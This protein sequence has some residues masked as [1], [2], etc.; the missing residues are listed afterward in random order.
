MIIGDV[1]V[2]FD[3]PSTRL[4]VKATIITML[5]EMISINQLEIIIIY[6]KF[7]DNKKNKKIY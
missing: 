4:I 5:I 1:L 3:K 6:I 7:K 2:D